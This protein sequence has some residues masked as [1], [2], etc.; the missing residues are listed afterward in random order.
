MGEK[1]AEKKKFAVFDFDGTLIR[2][3]L[4][5]AL[6]D[7]LA[8]R[9]LVDPQQYEA[10][11]QSRL[12]WKKRTHSESFKDY[13]LHLVNLFDRWITTLSTKQFDDAA[14]S[15]FE[16]YRDQVYIFTRDLI[17]KLQKEKYL[18]FAISGS[19]GE[20][21][22]KIARYYGF[23]DFVGAVFERDKGGFTGKRTTTLGGKD[24]IL[25]DLVSKHNA[26]YINSVAVGDT[27]SD[28]AMLE[29]VEQPIAF[30]PTEKLF[31][32]AVENKWKLVI[33]RKNMVYQL[34]AKN[35]KYILVETN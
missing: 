29:L 17:R 6:A 22:E 25:K 4:Y 27:E 18:L 28:I 15:V 26:N 23:D 5:H 21:V 10:I 2:W 32:H 9:G 12:L 20:I 8:K 33:E 3:Q 24:K 11:K 30:N 35:G 14:Q 16:E 19:Q 1:A 7:T 34:E 13:E 31:K